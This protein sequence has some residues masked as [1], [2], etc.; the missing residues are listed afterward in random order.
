MKEGSLLLVVIKSEGGGDTLF[1][2]RKVNDHFES[3]DSMLCGFVQMKGKYQLTSMDPLE[4]ENLSAWADLK[5]KEAGRR[6]FWWGGKGKQDFGWRT[7]SVRSF[8]GITEPAFRVF[9]REVNIR[10][11]E[12]FFG[13]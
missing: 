10:A 1:L 4:L 11:Q 13:L 8:L 12:N 7:V 6:P 9:K 3:L 2:L 5:Q